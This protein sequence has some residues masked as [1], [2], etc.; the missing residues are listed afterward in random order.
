MVAFNKPKF[1]LGET[2]ATPDAKRAILKA[3][4]SPAVFLDRHIVGDWGDVSEYDRQANETALVDGD[5]IFSVYKTR[6]G[7]KLWVITEA[8]GDDGKR[9]STCLMLPHEY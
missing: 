9:A 6:L 7:T 3:G 1:E 4:E 8:V 2:V 5:R